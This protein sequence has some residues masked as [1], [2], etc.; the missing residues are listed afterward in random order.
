MAGTLTLWT[1]LVITL[2]IPILAPFVGA[3]GIMRFNI[4]PP[5]VP[6]KPKPIVSRNQYWS[7]RK[8]H[9][10]PFPR[11]QFRHP[12]HPQPKY[13]HPPA[14]LSSLFTWPSIDQNYN[15]TNHSS[16]TTTPPTGD[17]VLAV[18]L[19]PKYQ[20]STARLS[21]LF[22]WSSI[23]LNYNQTNRSPAT[24]TPP[25]GDEELAVVVTVILMPIFL[26]LLVLRF[27]C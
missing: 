16:S 18:H 27:V 15:Q 7:D 19:Q 9:F 14:R 20:H 22:T 3:R 4:K 25:T 23:D 26:V 10:P 5:R 8:F 13:R 2:T 12:L 1:F 21:S 24:T 17:E 11:T 6:A